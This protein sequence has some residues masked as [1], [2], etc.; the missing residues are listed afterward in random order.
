MRNDFL[1]HRFPSFV[2]GIVPGGV[3]KAKE[4]VERH[5]S[6][7]GGEILARSFGLPQLSPSSSML[8]ASQTN[9]GMFI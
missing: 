1:Q 6:I 5:I 4:M 7:K 8:P 3:N 2:P 9:D